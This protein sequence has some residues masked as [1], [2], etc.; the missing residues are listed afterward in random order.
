MNLIVASNN[1]NKIREIREIIGDRFEILS[2]K[3]VNI[4]IEIIED[5]QT[6]EQNALIKARTIS[7]LMPYHAVLADDSGLCVKA[8]DG[9]PGIYSARYSGENATDESN[10]KKLLKNME[11]IADR[12]ARFVCCMA[13]ILPDKTQPIICQGIC[14]GL[15]GYE[16][17]GNNGFGYDSIF[18][19]EEEDKT[20]AQ[21]SEE[22]KN[23]ISHRRKALD[24]I[25]F[26]V[27]A[28]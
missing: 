2:L 5:G 17:K 24:K 14:N 28:F 3:D 13:L 20:L 25:N 19:I 4:D 10:R 11:D 21:L 1:K 15:I 27:R 8:L 6:F 23:K 16:E 18:I 12:K 9:A 22:E 7:K 26:L